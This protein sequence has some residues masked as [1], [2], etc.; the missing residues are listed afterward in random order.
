MK[1]APL[2]SVVWLRALSLSAEDE[3]KS[4]D[5]FILAAVC[6]LVEA[7]GAGKMRNDHLYD[8][9]AA[10]AYAVNP[11]L[12]KDEMR[13]AVKEFVGWTAPLKKRARKRGK[14]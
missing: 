11:G 3:T 2:S 13:A 14:R 8:A 9:V 7:R 6:S 10:I 1:T 12:T 5:A 4:S